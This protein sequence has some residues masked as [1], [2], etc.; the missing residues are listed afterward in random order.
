MLKWV[1]DVPVT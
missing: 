1:F